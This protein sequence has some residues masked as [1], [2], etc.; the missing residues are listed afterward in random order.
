MQKHVR[1]A[2]ASGPPQVELACTCSTQ[3]QGCACTPQLVARAQGTPNFRAAAPCCCICTLLCGLQAGLLVCMLPLLHPEGCP[4]AADHLLSLCKLACGA[5]LHQY[6]ACVGLYTS[7]TLTM[8]DAGM[9]A[10]SPQHTCQGVA[11]C[12]DVL[13]ALL[14]CFHCIRLAHAVTTISMW[15]MCNVCIL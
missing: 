15:E 1:Q 5:A 12:S 9:F 13:H 14:L 2:R 7:H 6:V 11:N 4:K 3:L 10:E 8:L